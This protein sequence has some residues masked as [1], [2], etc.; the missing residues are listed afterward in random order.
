MTRYRQTMK[1]TIE[2]LADSVSEATD[3]IREEYEQWDSALLWNPD[4]TVEVPE[5]DEDFFPI[6]EEW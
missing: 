3:I 1:I 6:N 4:T 2:V 5:D